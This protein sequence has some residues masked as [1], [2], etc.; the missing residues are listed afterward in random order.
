M[1]DK[2]IS[3]YVHNVLP[4]S[5]KKIKRY[6]IMPD[7]AIPIVHLGNVKHALGS[8]RVIASAEQITSVPLM[9]PIVLENVR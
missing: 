5:A 8:F 1:N 9:P 2:T 3:I 4:S 7:C 6:T